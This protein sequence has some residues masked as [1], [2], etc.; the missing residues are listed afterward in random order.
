MTHEEGKELHG[1]LVDYVSNPDFC[2]FH[3]WRQNDL[4]MWDNRV[5]LHRAMEYDLTKYRRGLRRT[6]VAGDVPVM[7]PYWPESLAVTSRA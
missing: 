4:V 2:Y 7:G 1:W 6:T 5:L 3:R